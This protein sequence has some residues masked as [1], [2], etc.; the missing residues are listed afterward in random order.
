MDVPYFNPE[1]PPFD[2]EL[3]ADR[4]YWPEG[5]KDTDT[6]EPRFV[7]RIVRERRAADAS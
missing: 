3:S 2:P 6:M 1:L 5:E 4:L 7:L